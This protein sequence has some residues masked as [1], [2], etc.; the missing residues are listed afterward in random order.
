M[1]LNDAPM[2]QDATLVSS[3][4]IG[5]S[6]APA[7]VKPRWDPKGRRNM[8]IIGGVVGVAVL[9]L[10]LLFLGGKGKEDKKASVIVEARS[11][12]PAVNGMMSEADRAAIS[13]QENARI[14]AALSGQQSAVGAAVQPGAAQPIS[15][16]PQTNAPLT[17]QGEVRLNQQQPSPPNGGQAPA[18]SAPAGPDE[19][20]M[21][22]L[23]SQMTSMMAAWGMNAGEGG[24]R[25]LSTYV[26]D[27]RKGGN[28]AAGNQPTQEGS[29][30]ASGQR[31]ANDLMIVKAYDAPYAAEMISGADSDTPGKVRARILSG[32]LAGAVVVGATRRIGDQGFQTDFSTASFNGHTIKITAYGMD[33]EAPGDIVR[34][35]YDGRYMQ[36][37]VF[38]VVAEG[39][40]AYAGARAQVGTQVIAIALP[41]AG[42]GAVTGA[43]QT[44]P[45]SAEQARNAMYSSGA[46][47]VSRALATGPQDGHVL[48]EPGKQIGIVFEESIYQSDL[49]GQSRQG[50]K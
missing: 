42:T 29:S 6:A 21:K 2:A 24:Q 40:K 13:R 8:I 43:Q 9:M 31:A 49:A 50:N 22:G 4:A 3:E 27:S 11:D 28:G 37:Y 16:Q 1:Q 44:P 35:E 7:Q 32:P 25:T 20:K 23:E 41:G 15:A 14:A 12:Q 18:P 17:Q 47:Q 34:G 38:P 33:G 19:S 30:R 39:V 5:G 36:R 46:N 10:M 48:L 26:R 45:P